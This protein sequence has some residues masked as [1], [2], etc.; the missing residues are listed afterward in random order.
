MSRSPVVI[1][2]GGSK[3]IGL[4]VTSIL[5]SE[6]NASVVTLSRSIT[7]GLRDLESDRLLALECDVANESAVQSAVQ[8]AIEKF[9][10][11][12]GLI[13]NAGIIA[14]ICRIGD[15]TPISAWKE[16]F[17]INF[18]S[19]VT[20]ITA[21]LPSLRES[22]L[23]GKIVFVSSGA[24]EG[25]AYSGW[26]AY[27]ASKA[28]MNSLCRT[29]AAEDPSVI[30]VAVRPGIVDTDMQVEI[31]GTGSLAMGPVHQK[32]VDLH[33]TGSLLKPEDPGHV[34][35]ALAVDCP[36]ELSGEF[37]SWNDEVCK[38]FMLK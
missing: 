31:R 27:S 24:A 6:F 9:N 23:G 20:T 33:Q 25:S 1:I 11:I 3:G 18:F 12:D 35:A 19:L 17:D 15:Q 29:L 14:P 37:V 5:L 38:P 10:R 7:S 22:G 8:K 21:T 34:I 28:A 32:F 16:C 30:S 26:G 13:L 2:A 36:K 4:A